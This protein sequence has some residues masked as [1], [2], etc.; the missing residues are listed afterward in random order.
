M[1]LVTGALGFIGSHL[2]DLLI[3]QE[4]EFVCL[5]NFGYAANI[6][7]YRQRENQITVL[8]RDLA[9]LASLKS[10]FDTYPIKTIYHLA[11]ETHVDNSIKNVDPFISSNILGTVNLLKMAEQY[12]QVDRFV[13]ISTDE[14][15][16]HVPEGSTNEST[17]YHTRNPYS[18]SKAASDHFVTAWHHTYGVPTVITHCS[19]N[20]G[21]RQH[22]EKMIPTIIRSL[23]NNEPVPVY[24]DGLQ[25]RDWLYVGDHCEALT[26]VGQHA[27]P[28]PIYN[29]GADHTVEITNIELVRMICDLLDRP[30]SLIK[31]VEDRKGHDRRYS[32]DSSLIR[33]EL[34]WRPKTTLNQGLIKILTQEVEDFAKRS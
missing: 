5:D 23:K 32:I 33:R 18:A 1:I 20:Y 11:A 12:Q 27:N 8:G 19:N 6:N 31:H 17:P 34:G 9:D 15:Y 24:G 21:P 10:V 14:V 30:Y 16:G 26:L 29:I 25:I 13:H 2:V 7:Y 4:Q 28:S 3:E 22:S